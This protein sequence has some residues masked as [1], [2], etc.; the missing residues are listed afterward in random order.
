MDEPIVVDPQWLEERLDEPSTIAVDVRP[1]PFYGQAHLPNAVSLPVFMVMGLAA[2]SPPLQGMGEMLGN[3]GIRPGTHIVAYDDGASTAAATLF[4]LLRMVN[5]PVASVLD[6]G[7]TRWMHEGRRTVHDR[8][9]REPVAYEVDELNRRLWVET[10][11]L[12][13]ALDRNDL[14]V[15]D[16]R[17]P[18]EYLGLESTA[19]RDGHIPGAVNVDWRNHLERDEDGLYRMRSDD[20]LRDLY[21]QAGVTQ[22]KR[23]VV[24]CQVGQRASLAFLALQKLGYPDV[25]TYL[26][27]WQE[28]GNR[29]DTP[30]EPE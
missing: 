2:G 20:A 30:V 18:A 6:G 25:V 16:V 15:V 9:R 4:R 29:R 1:P 21:A 14:V 23:V 3:L 26:P 13:Q 5:H 11:E 22:D 12:L 28:W 24:Y 7:I 17:S 8:V 19:A 27:G 10:D